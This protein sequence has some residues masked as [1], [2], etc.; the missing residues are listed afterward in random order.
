MAAVGAR[1]NF[2]AR[3][4]DLSAR[5]GER[6]GSGAALEVATA[7]FLAGSGLWHGKSIAPKR[8]SRIRFLLERA[9]AG[10]W[11]GSG[12]LLQRHRFS[13][14][15]FP[16]GESLTREVHHVVEGVKFL[17]LSGA[18]VAE[19]DGVGLGPDHGAVLL[20]DFSGMHGHAHLLLGMVVV[21]THV[22]VIEEGQHLGAM[23]AQPFDKALGVRVRPGGG[24][25]LIEPSM[26]PVLAPFVTFP[27]QVSHGAPRGAPHRAADERVFCG[28]V[29]R[30]GQ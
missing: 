10:R 3:D 15:G 8:C 14:G 4:I 19:K 6:V 23:A 5:E 27:R 28:S 12:G 9:R 11:L 2:D 17:Q 7:T 29:A 18:E 1:V 22:A 24:D 26:E 20:T 16:C 21:G 13:G 30:A 25:E